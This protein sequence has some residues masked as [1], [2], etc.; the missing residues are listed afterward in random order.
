MHTKSC[1]LRVAHSSRSDCLNCP[2]RLS[3]VCLFYA[4]CLLF[5]S[6]SKVEAYDRSDFF[7]ADNTEKGVVALLEVANHSSLSIFASFVF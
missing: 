4:F 5:F 7:G 6:E 2:L 3:S 1:I